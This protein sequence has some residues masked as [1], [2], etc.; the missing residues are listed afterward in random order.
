[1]PEQQEVT[2]MGG[3]MRLG[4]YPCRPQE[5]TITAAAYQME[6][7]DERHRHRFE[8][9]NAYRETLEESGL[10]IGG[11]SPDGKL[12][13]TTEVHDHPFMVGV[14]FHPEFQSRPNR[15]HPLFCHFV[16][17]AKETV[18]EGSQRP[19]PLDG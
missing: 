16:G 17:A 7:T 2:D 13:E 18:R 3:S 12:V 9:N 19:L 10:V 8:L 11:L 15:P 14:Q 6:E 5:N 4:V 1:M